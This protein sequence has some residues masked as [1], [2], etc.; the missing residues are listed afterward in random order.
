MPTTI[1]VVGGG[2][3]GLMALKNLREDGF[4][5]TVYETREYAGGLWKP[6]T[7]DSLSI[8]E[9]TIFNSSRFRTA[10]T[11]FPVPDDMD[12]F[13]TGRQ[14]YDY[15]NSYCDHFNLWPHIKFNSR[16]RT[17]R[18][19]DDRWELD[20][21]TSDGSSSKY[22]SFDKVVFACG[23]FINP[24]QPK[25][26]SIENFEGEAL[27]A[28]RYYDPAK[29]KDQNVLVIG[30]HAS[31]QDVVTGL[32]KHAK[33]VYISHRSGMRIVSPIIYDNTE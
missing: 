15:F 7:D 3:L 4:D 23:S 5:A 25:F 17:A 32:S 11:D 16:I 33:K 24:R 27:H 8:V 18:R 10:A 9:N 31:A 30:L 19:L 13:P 14:V 28:L 6:S 20:I 21:E 1:A 22:E 12:D 2:P 26:E 29:Y